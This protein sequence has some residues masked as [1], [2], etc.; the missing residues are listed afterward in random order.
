MIN[1]IDLS[2]EEKKLILSWRNHPNIRKWMYNQNI[3]ELKDHLNFIESL[4]N[5]KD[6]KY[7]VV[8]KDDTYIGVIDFNNITKQSLVMGIYKN[9]N[10]YKSGNILLNTLIHYAFDIL[11]VDTIFSEV[12]DENEKA[13]ALYKKYNFQETGKKVIG[14]KDITCMEL[15]QKGNI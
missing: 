5:S 14:G 3:I 13:K 8:K 1:F 12:F 4:K 15:K 9:P 2:L 10:T 6:K 7:F 11:N